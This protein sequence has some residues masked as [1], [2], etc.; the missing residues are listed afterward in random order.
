MSTA[1]HRARGMYMTVR[2][3]YGIIGLYTAYETD[4]SIRIFIAL[5]RL[6]GPQEW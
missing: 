4:R 5:I 2:F 6:L 1:S 3:S